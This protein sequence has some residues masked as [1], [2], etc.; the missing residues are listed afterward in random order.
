MNQGNSGV[1]L[2]GGGI[3]CSLGTSI[4][5]ITDALLSAHH[6]SNTLAIDWFEDSFVVPWK[7]INGMTLDDTDFGRLSNRQD[8]FLYEVVDK[9]L[10]CLS[11]AEYRSDKLGIFLG[12][13]SFEVG[14]SEFN[15]H[16]SICQFG[17]E[18]AMPMQL[19][20]YGNLTSKLRRKFNLTGPDFVF[21]TACSASAN[22]ILSA[23]QMLSAGVIDHALVVGIETY[24]LTTLAGFHVM[25]LLAS[26]Q[27]KPFDI[28]RTGLILGEACAAIVL[29][30]EG[31]SSLRVQGGASQCDTDSVTGASED[32]GA[33]ASVIA[34]AL[35]DCA[36]SVEEISFIKAHGTASLSNDKAEAAALSRMFSRMPPLFSLKGSLGHTLGACGVVELLCLEALLGQCLIPPTTGF[37]D[38]DSALGI[39]PTTT[40]Q[41]LQS[42]G[43]GLLNHLGFGG[44]NT[45]LVVSHE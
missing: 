31:Q 40:P 4:E 30:R 12:S 25:Q 43:H 33:V 17:V 41:K 9:A 21:G 29:A 23:Q 7:G 5:R 28:N 2:I 26:D 8:S 6:L 22:A 10:V 35:D 34:R 24:N 38:A 20:S 45:I 3:A 42:G 18:Q 27:V 19:V 36:I 15:Y 11:P 14:P 44:N 37:S 13:S 32:G 16:Q 1:A 39:I